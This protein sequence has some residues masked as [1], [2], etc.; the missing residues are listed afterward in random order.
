MNRLLNVGFELAGHWLLEDGRIRCELHRLATQANVLYAFVCDGRVM[1]VGKST[2]QLSARMYGYANPGPT[3]LTNIANNRRIAALLDEGAAVDI[4]VLPDSGLLHFG[5]FHLNLA[6]ALEDDI[7]RQ[8]RPP[9]NGSTKQD[10]VDRSSPPTAEEH[11][12]DSGGDAAADADAD[13]R[14]LD[15]ASNVPSDHPPVAAAAPGKHATMVLAFILQRTYFRTGFFN[16]GV[17]GSNRFGAN[18]ARIEI[19]RGSEVMPIIGYINRTANS[20][21]TPRIMGG[22]GLRDWFQQVASIGDRMQ[23]EVMS[24]ESIRIRPQA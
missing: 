19:Y 23:V 21:G 11:F 15:Q 4:L 16:V 24:P 8:I 3:Q 17:D 13:G 5:S 9:W 1:Y 18:G 22:V 10:L 20:N 12:Q 14:I 2:R 7:I 6:A